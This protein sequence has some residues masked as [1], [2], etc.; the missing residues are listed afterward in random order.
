[1]KFVSYK[2]QQ[3]YGCDYTI[4]CG[5]DVDIFEAP[6]LSK[7][8][9]KILELR[10]GWNQI[11]DLDSF[12]DRVIIESASKYFDDEYDTKLDKWKLF[13]VVEEVDLMPLIEQQKKLL[14]SQLEKIKSNIKDKEDK[15][16]YEELKK[17]FGD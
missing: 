5:M 6:S 15:L 10:E 12:H 8:V 9:E 7:A 1:M 16:K 3:G 17:K 2:K 11:E 4:G 14:D 13:Q